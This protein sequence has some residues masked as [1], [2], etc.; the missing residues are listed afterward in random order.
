MLEWVDQQCPNFFERYPNLSLVN[1]L[2]TT[3]QASNNLRKK[4]CIGY[5]WQQPKPLSSFLMSAFHSFLN[6]LYA[7]NIDKQW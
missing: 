1:T 5:F 3:T 6:Y 7:N 2:Q 4:D